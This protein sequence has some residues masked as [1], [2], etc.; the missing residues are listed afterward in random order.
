MGDFAGNWSDHRAKLV[1]SMEAMAKNANECR[2][3]TDQYDSKM[4]QY[5]T[6]K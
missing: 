1:A 3:A 4:Q 2:T 5:L 6:G